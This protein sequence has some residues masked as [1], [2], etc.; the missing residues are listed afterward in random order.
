MRRRFPLVLASLVL[1]VVVL[2]GAAQPGTATPSSSLT[3]APYLT[4]LVKR[5]VTVNWATTTAITRG[6]VAYGREGVE[7]CDAHRTTATPIAITVGLVTETQWSAD[8]NNLLHDTAYCYSIYG[9][10][11]NLLGT[12]TPPAFRSQ[13]GHGSTVAVTCGVFGDWGQVDGMGENADQANLM[14]QI[15]SSGARF[16]ATTG[17]TGYPAGRRKNYGASQQTRGR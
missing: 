14:S 2:L 4:D 15:A 7:A 1:S 5:H 13:L 8:L 10:P 3:R 6:H 9:G 16:A 11:Q 17:D 12:D